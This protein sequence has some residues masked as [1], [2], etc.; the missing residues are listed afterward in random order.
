MEKRDLIFYNKYYDDNKKHKNIHKNRFRTF[1]QTTFSLLKLKI[2][3]LWK[4]ITAKI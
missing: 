3:K 2:K 1:R 4:K